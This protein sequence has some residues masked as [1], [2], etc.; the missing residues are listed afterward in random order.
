MDGA[1]QAAGTTAAAVGMEKLGRVGVLYHGL[2]VLGGGAILGGLVLG[3][4][5]VFII[6]KKF[7]EA[8][9]FAAAGAVMTF[10]GFMHGESVGIAVTPGVAFAYAA[11]AAFLYG[12]SRMPSEASASAPAPMHHE[13]KGVPAE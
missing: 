2:E 4:I 6:E 8:S 1:L 7:V 11:V 9:A 13:L 5:A 3:A 10:F 12:L